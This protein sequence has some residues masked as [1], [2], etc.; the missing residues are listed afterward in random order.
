MTEKIFT[1]YKI[2]LVIGLILWNVYFISI[3]NPMPIYVDLLIVIVYLGKF[4]WKKYKLDTCTAKYPIALVYFVSA[5]FMVLFEETLAA[6]T[7]SLKEGFSLGLF[8]VRIGQFWAFNVLAFSGVIIAMYVSNRLRIIERKELMVMIAFFGIYG[9]SAYLLG[10][11]S[12]FI[13]FMVYT[14]IVMLIY[15]LIFSPAIAVLPAKE[16][17]IMHP[18]RRY[19]S[20]AILI[21]LFSV[22]FIMGLSELRKNNPDYF[23]PCSMI[24]CD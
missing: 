10:G 3:G 8:T 16:I 5:Y 17:R 14:P 21:F 20:V 4:L 7:W 11:V 6:L 13:I 15:Y 24:D 18:V 12:G 23:P 1:I 22:P 2:W 9:E 19:V